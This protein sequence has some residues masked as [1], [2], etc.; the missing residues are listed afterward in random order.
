MTLVAEK[1]S[2]YDDIVILYNH[3]RITLKKILFFIKATPFLTINLLFM[4]MLSQ[5][6]T[7]SF[8]QSFKTALSKAKVISSSIINKSNTHVFKQLQ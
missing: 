6:C 4:K 2:R 7:I 3:D 1:R 8:E 5:I